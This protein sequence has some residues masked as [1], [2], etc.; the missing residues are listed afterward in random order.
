MLSTIEIILFVLLLFFIFLILY[1]LGSC[2]QKQKEGYTTSPI[3]TNTSPT[4]T[5]TSNPF[6]FYKS[7]TKNK[8]N[9]TE[10]Y[11]T[12]FVTNYG[13]TNQD[14]VDNLN[15]ILSGFSNYVN[16]LQ[17][18][19]TL[20]VV[21]NIQPTPSYY[22]STY[23]PTTPVVTQ[24]N[25][26]IPILFDGTKYLTVGN[27]GESASSN[28]LNEY[29]SSFTIEAWVKSDIYNQS[30]SQSI[31]YETAGKLYIPTLVVDMNIKEKDIFWS[32]GPTNDGRLVYYVNNGNDSYNFISFNSIASA[33]TTNG[34][35][36][37]AL[38]SNGSQLFFF[39]NGELQESFVDISGNNNNNLITNIGTYSDRIGN[40][41]LCIGYNGETST[42]GNV[43]NIRINN[44][45]L[46]TSSRFTPKPLTNVEGTTLLVQNVGTNIQDISPNNY[47]INIV[48][49]TAIPVPSNTPEIIYVNL[50][51][52]MP[53]CE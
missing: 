44:K 6:N 21:C 22:E 33:T 30:M 47:I 23:A 15:K 4:P 40:G 28:I 51:P 5:N 12:Y 18:D 29:Q 20:A 11:S 3:S 10:I 32:F 25:I 17:D 52:E 7:F 35:V 49:I 38:E 8:I 43:R 45:N 36:H 53:N 31:D 24:N 48:P 16:N 34:Y 27:V 50:T 41:T 1:Y 2:I 9:I 26:I 19:E 14:K 42:H 13:T 46:Y 39:I 37:I